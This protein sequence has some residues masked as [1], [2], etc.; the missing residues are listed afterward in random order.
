MCSHNLLLKQLQ[1]LNNVKWT[2]KER[3]SKYL[4]SHKC[5]KGDTITYEWR[6]CSVGNTSLNLKQWLNQVFGLLPVPYEQLT[7]M[8]TCFHG[9]SLPWHSTGRLASW[10]SGQVCIN[11][12]SHEDDQLMRLL[13]EGAD[14]RQGN[15]V[16]QT[17]RSTPLPLGSPQWRPVKHIKQ[18]VI[19]MSTA[20]CSV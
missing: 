8:S 3:P 5:Y 2:H 16:C 12:S 14:D 17:G 20:P 9:N 7:W 4:N 10:R 13:R 6:V 19:Q 15:C 11:L 1:T 18:V